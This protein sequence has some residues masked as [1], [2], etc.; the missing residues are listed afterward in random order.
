MR[1]KLS[2]HYMFQNER[3]LRR[4]SLCDECRVVDIAQDPQALDGQIR[5][6]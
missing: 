3:A 4:L 1:S 5:Q 6:Y 2:G